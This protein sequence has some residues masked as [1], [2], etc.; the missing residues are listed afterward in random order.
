MRVCVC[1]C[2]CL[3]VC[4]CVC[5][6]ARARVCVSK[7]KNGDGAHGADQRKCR[8]A[9]FTETKKQS[10]NTG[11]RANNTLHKELGY[12]IGEPAKQSVRSAP[13]GTPRTASRQ[14]QVCDG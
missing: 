1:V 14:R 4:L 7:G 11:A 3:C 9:R 10:P 2:M 8:Q 6:C 5:V 12:P 13:L